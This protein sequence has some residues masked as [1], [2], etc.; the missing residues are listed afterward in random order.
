[1]KR[2]YIRPEMES[3]KLNRL[4]RGVLDESGGGVPWNASREVDSGDIEG[5]DTEFEDDDWGSDM[6]NLWQR[7]GRSPHRSLWN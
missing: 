6:E 3:L 1:M 5:K 2:A 7:G 4:C